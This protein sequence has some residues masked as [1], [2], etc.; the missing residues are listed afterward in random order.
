[1]KPKITH[2]KI[3]LNYSDKSTT[4]LLD[5]NKDSKKGNSYCIYNKIIYIKYKYSS[6]YIK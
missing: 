6:I 3:L 5:N 4:D 2:Y 1:M